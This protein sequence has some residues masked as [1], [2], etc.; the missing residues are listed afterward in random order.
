MSFKGVFFSSSKCDMKINFIYGVLPNRIKQVLLHINISMH[1]DSFVNYSR[2]WL[3]SHTSVFLLLF[4]QAKNKVRK[5][6]NENAKAYAINKLHW[7]L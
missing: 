1:F 6:I 5:V 7:Q 2:S 4:L 3:P